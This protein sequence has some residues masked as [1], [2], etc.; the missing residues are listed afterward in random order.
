MIHKR[1]NCLWGGWILTEKTALCHV[2]TITCLVKMFCRGLALELV[3]GK[4][5]KQT[6]KYFK[7]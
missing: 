4:L 7:L 1:D 6:C 3:S 5:E 2:A